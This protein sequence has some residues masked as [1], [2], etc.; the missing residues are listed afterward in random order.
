[1]KD[2]G[3]EAEGD[4][5]PS[6]PEA[7]SERSSEDTPGEIQG[8]EHGVGLELEL[9]SEGPVRPADAAQGHRVHDDQ[10]VKWDGEVRRQYEATVQKQQQLDKQGR[11]GK[12][13]IA[14]IDGECPRG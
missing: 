14:K 1:M 11:E 2:I 5:A 3:L 10:L 12:E 6:T 8:P 13:E 7:K 9:S 4:P